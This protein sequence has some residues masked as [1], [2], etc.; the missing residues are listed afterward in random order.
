MEVLLEDS[1]T[2]QQ[3]SEAVICELSQVKLM[4]KGL[5]PING[6]VEQ[7]MVKQDRMIEDLQ[8]HNLQLELDLTHT[9]L[10]LLKWFI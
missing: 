4:I 1:A 9:K 5:S 2:P 3:I 10:E 7:S 8:N 6:K